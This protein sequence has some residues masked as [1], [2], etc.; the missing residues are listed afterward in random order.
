M[1]LPSFYFL[2]QI[3]VIHDFRR[4]HNF[5]I[6]F[7]P[8]SHSKMRDTSISRF[9]FTLKSQYA[10]QQILIERILKSSLDSMLKDY[11]ELNPCLDKIKRDLRCSITIYIK[12]DSNLLDELCNTD[13]RSKGTREIIKELFHSL[14]QDYIHRKFLNIIAT[15]KKNLHHKLYK[16]KQK[17]QEIR[18]QK[19]YEFTKL[20]IIKN[21]LKQFK[22]YK[23]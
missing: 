20:K 21:Q 15:I 3:F 23:I 17:R 18:L 4:R 2:K 6:D 1:H 5:G 14:L 22:L 8:I 11:K 13:M 19:A 9:L 16:I 7:I 12:Q 10:K